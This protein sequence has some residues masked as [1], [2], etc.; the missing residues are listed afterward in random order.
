[1]QKA[2]FPP[3]KAG[4]MPMQATRLCVL[5]GAPKQTLTSSQQEQTRAAQALLRGP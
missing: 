3:L 5:T 1:M 4:V 2:L